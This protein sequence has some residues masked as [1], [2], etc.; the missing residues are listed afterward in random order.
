MRVLY[1]IN[2]S[3]LCQCQGQI[4]SEWIQNAGTEVFP[5]IACLW[6]S[7][8]FKVNDGSGG[9]MLN[10]KSP[11]LL[12]HGF[13]YYRVTASYSNHSNYSTTCFARLLAVLCSIPR[14]ESLKL[15]ES[16]CPQT[17]WGPKGTFTDHFN[18]HRGGLSLLL[19]LLSIGC[20]FQAYPF[21]IKEQMTVVDLMDEM[22]QAIDCQM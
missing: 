7:K 5:A 12:L 10:W 1:R 21:K 9:I 16:L 18:F 20:F 6:T 8:A 3:R 19:L 14:R 2:H 22:E 15:R 11:V 17:L 4:C 13:V